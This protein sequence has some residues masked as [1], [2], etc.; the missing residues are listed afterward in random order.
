MVIRIAG[1]QLY[2]VWLDGKQKHWQAF[3]KTCDQPGYHGNTPEK[4]E[5]L[6]KVNQEVP[7]FK[8]RFDEDPFT[9]PMQDGSYL[10]F[11]P[12]TTEPRSDAAPLH[13]GTLYNFSYQRN[14]NFGLSEKRSANQK[15]SHPKEFDSNPGRMQTLPG[16]IVYRWKG[17][18]PL[19]IKQNIYVTGNCSQHVYPYKILTEAGVTDHFHEPCCV[20]VVVPGE[21]EGEEETFDLGLFASDEYESNADDAVIFR[22]WQEE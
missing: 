21:K 12:N 19:R 6:T 3:M 22:G 14:P 4:E 8:Q 10:V 18:N 7:G 1:H 9:K 20:S 2:R 17:D 15:P 16:T 13:R 11:M 5:F